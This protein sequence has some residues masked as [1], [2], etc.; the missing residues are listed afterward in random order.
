MKRKFYYP[1]ISLLFFLQLACSQ[2]D[3]AQDS[4]DIMTLLYNKES[5]IEFPPPSIEDLQSGKYK[6]KKVDLRTDTIENANYAINRDCV[7]NNQ[8]QLYKIAIPEG[9]SNLVEQFYQESNGC[10]IDEVS[11]VDIDGTPI[12]KVDG[13]F[14]RDKLEKVKKKHNVLG[15]VSYSHLVFDKNGE[16]AIICFGGTREGLD[17]KWS[18]YFMEKKGGK[19]QINTSRTL[20]SS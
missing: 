12:P 15:I 17:S 3:K 4:K 2:N 5:N 14:S 18:I 10:W 6:P 20:S 9:Y 11:I 7:P 16:K 8:N 13:D 1:L 19:W